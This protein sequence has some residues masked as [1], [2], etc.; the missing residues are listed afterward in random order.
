MAFSLTVQTFWSQV[1]LTDPE[2]CPQ[3]FCFRC[4]FK[5]FCSVCNG[6]FHD[7]TPYHASPISCRFLCRVAAWPDSTQMMVLVA[8]ASA[9]HIFCKF[10]VPIAVLRF[11]EAGV[12]LS[13]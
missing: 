9:F 8:L 6:C 4:F 5:I 2:C 7:M 13:P 3:L 1:L 12:Q 10:V 11:S